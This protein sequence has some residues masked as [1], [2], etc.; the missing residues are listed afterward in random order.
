MFLRRRLYLVEAQYWRDKEI[1]N[2]AE[3]FYQSLV[4][5]LET[6][7]N[8]LAVRSDGGYSVHAAKFWDHPRARKLGVVFL[9][10]GKIAKFRIRGGIGTEQGTNLKVLVFPI[11]I[12]PFDMRHLST[13]LYK[14]HV[15][16]E[17]VHYLDPGFRFGKV[18]DLERV[19]DSEYYNSSA[20]WNAFWQEGAAA[21]ERMLKQIKDNEK[22]MDVFF[23]DGSLKQ[24][25][26]RADKFWAKD[27]LNN[28][29]VETERKFDKR[30]AQLWKE[31]KDRNLF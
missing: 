21:F 30:F 10:E 29:S 26:E 25:R 15:I 16:H 24:A 17:V 23:G 11:M 22:E 4:R 12:G 14:D 2:V 7:S 31:M 13:R 18:S 19:S 6:R 5:F 8:E 1:R 9:P 27:F 28:M 20:E 3:E